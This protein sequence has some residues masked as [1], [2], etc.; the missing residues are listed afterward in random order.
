MRRLLVGAALTILAGAHF[1]VPSVVQ[2][3]GTVGAL[4]I[5]DE[6][7][8]E[9]ERIDA[10]AG[11][12]RYHVPSGTDAFHIAFDFSGNT[13]TDV[14][15]RVMGPMGTIL[16]Q[17]TDTY[18]APGT[19]VI[20]F[21]N[22]GIPLEDNEYVVNAY[23]GDEFYLADSLQLAVGEAQIPESREVDSPPDSEG[24]LPQEPVSAMPG[25][26]APDLG[27][28]GATPGGPPARLLVLAGLAVVVLL[29]VV[30]WAGWS[31]ARHS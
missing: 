16:Q 29:A 3:Q 20:E 28:E 24:P 22:G 30:A 14:Q 25:P 4:R 9:I 21:D 19:H 6:T 11:E 2:G 15:I 26:G 8:T 10:P 27:A 13:P 31:F 7:G 17:E 5:S 12:K 18:S 1:V 23:V